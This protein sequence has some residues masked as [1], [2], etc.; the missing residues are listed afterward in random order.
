ME[1]KQLAYITSLGWLNESKI[2]KSYALN[3]VTRASTTGGLVGI[4]EGKII[5]SY[6]SGNVYTTGD[7]AGGFV[8]VNSGSIMDCYAVENVGGTSYIGG[9]AGINK[10]DE[11]SYCYATGKITA[12]GSYAGGVVGVNYA[13]VTNCVAANKSVK[14]GFSNVNRIAGANSSML[15]NNYASEDLLVNGA[16]VIGGMH[17]DVNGESTPVSTL[18]SFNFYSAGNNW[19]NNAPWSMDINDNQHEIW[20]ICEGETLPF[21]QW[22]GFNCSKKTHKVE[23]NEDE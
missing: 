5:S 16:T 9:F 22:E 21:L 12:L 18:M 8:G 2:Q 1:R 7:E 13:T 4:N 3:N 20:K 19:F 11:I 6:A 10:Y 17:N 23:N 14:G 15:S